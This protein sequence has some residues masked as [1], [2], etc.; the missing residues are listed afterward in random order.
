MGAEVGHP[1]GSRLPV[2]EVLKNSRSKHGASN[3]GP[4][5]IYAL[6][7]LYTVHCTR[8]HIRVLPRLRCIHVV[9]ITLHMHT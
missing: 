6:S 9:Q 3:S 1:V 7:C 5:A 2:S 8:I 4:T